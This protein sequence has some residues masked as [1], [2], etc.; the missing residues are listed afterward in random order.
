MA[1]WIDRTR[2]NPYLMIG[3]CIAVWPLEALK[4][5]GVL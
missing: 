2:G 3:I 4:L 1:G 5:L